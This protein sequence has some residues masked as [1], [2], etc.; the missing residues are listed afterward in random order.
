VAKTGLDFFPLNCALDDKLEVFEAKCGIKGFGILLRLLQ[1]IYGDKGYYCDWDDDACLLFSDKIKSTPEE[2]QRVVSV[3]VERNIFSSEILEKHKILTSHGI[4]VRYL[5]G[6]A[7]KKK[8]ELIE[9]YILPDVDISRKNVCIISKNV[10][11]NQKN[12]YSFQQTKTETET[13]TETKTKTKKE[14]SS[15]DDVFSIFERCGFQITSHS[16]D[17]LKALSE[18]Y[19]EAWVIE[20][21]KRAADR[22]KKSL[23]YIKGI[24]SKWQIAGAVD[25]PEKPDA[26]ET[27]EAQKQAAAEKRKQVEAELDEQTEREMQEKVRQWREQ[28]P[29]APTGPISLDFIKT[30]YW[31]E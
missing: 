1:R 11:K 9:E 20:A 3:A 15:G 8:V 31:S 19:S 2:V 21:I 27:T 6:T 12:A 25:G 14:D 17:E 18:E 22:G 7:R 4:Q 26:K 30:I 5:Y 28:N 13:E 24:L 16:V 23:G 29:D 10:N